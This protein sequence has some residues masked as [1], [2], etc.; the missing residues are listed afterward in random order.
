[1]WNRATMANLLLSLAAFVA[2][3][4]VGASA[5]GFG[6]G[7][8]EL[9]IWMALAVAGAILILRRHL[10]AKADVAKATVGRH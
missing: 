7:V 3:M 2:F 5:L 1:M 9:T 10:A 8:P 4:V 6:M